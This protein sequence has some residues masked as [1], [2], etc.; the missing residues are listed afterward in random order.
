MRLR[1]SIYM[2]AALIKRLLD[3]S[4]LDPNRIASNMKGLSRSDCLQLVMDTI[5]RIFPST[6]RSG[7]LFVRCFDISPRLSYA[8]MALLGNFMIRRE[9]IFIVNGRAEFYPAPLEV[10]PRSAHP[11]NNLI[12]SFGG[13]RYWNRH[14]AQVTVACKRLDERMQQDNDGE[15]RVC[16]EPVA[17]GTRVSV[18]PCGHWYCK[19]CIGPW[20]ET[21]T[22][23]PTCRR[24]TRL[25]I[26]R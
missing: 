18:L 10:Q 26:Q 5:D 21:N 23:C 1:N 11:L 24:D 15:C 17:L 20:L 22:T 14:T 9:S 19:D 4:H 7:R 8:D 6:T 16:Q 3:N 12:M 2:T 25:P 13:A